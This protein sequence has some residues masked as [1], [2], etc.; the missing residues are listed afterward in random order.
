MTEHVSSKE[1]NMLWFRLLF[2]SITQKILAINILALAIPIGGL[3]YVGPYREGLIVSEMEGLRLE[4]SVFAGA[5]DRVAQLSMS[6][7]T[8]AF[9]SD[10]ERTLLR[11]N[12]F[13]IKETMLSILALVPIFIVFY[14]RV[15]MNAFIP[16]A[17]FSLTPGVGVAIVVFCGSAFLLII[18]GA[19]L[20]IR[21]F[22]K[23]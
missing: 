4:S 8:R 17:G 7:E 12:K 23:S 21:L 18:F 5:I 13:T 11:Y 20:A 6:L 3:L 16:E 1:G 15:K 22:G 2:S 14:G 19:T 10:N 9:G